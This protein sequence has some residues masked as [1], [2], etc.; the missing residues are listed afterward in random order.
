MVVGG[1]RVESYRTT[2]DAIE[3]AGSDTCTLKN[4]PAMVT[5]LNVPGQDILIGE[6]YFKKVGMTISYAKGG[7]PLVLCT[8]PDLRWLND[9]FSTPNAF[10]LIAGGLFLTG[11]LV[12]LTR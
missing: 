12:S 5:D 10:L 8:D 3:F 1:A 6:D 11:F 2:V 7:M 4:Q 9:P